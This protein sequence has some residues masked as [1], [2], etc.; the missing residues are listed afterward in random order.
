[1][2]ETVPGKEDL[3]WR[4]D[5]KVQPTPAQA[6]HT[7][8]SGGAPDCV[9][10][11]RLVKCQLAALEKRERRRGSN[12][13]DCPVSQ[14]RSRPTVGCAIRRRR[15]AHNNGRLGTPDCPVCTRQCPMRQPIPRANGRPHPIWKEIAHR[16]ATVAIRWCNGLSGAPLDRRQEMPSKLISNGS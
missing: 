15:V 16:T 11:P 2:L 3:N 6:W 4:K 7:R 9:R 1:V 5:G 12:S 10:C 13:P 14:R 8:L